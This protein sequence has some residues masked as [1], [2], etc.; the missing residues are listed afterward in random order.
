MEP[1]TQ[2]TSGKI[3]VSLIIG[4][5]L[6]FAAGAFWESRRSA[7]EL[8]Q[9]ESMVK[10]SGDTAATAAGTST[11][12]VST[13]KRTT[14]AENL[15]AVVSAPLSSQAGTSTASLLVENQSAGA[16]VEVTFVSVAWPV[17][18]AVRELKNGVQGNILG[19]AR[20]GA[21]TNGTVVRLLRSTV[22]GGHYAVVLY[23]DIG[24]QTFNYKEDVL[25]EG[26]RSEFI[27]E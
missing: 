19:A 18:V 3:I 12:V 26:V 6:G 5:I 20:V 11:I 9:S 7:V 22:A 23:R 24:D 15:S 27:A 25:I 4:L 13:E 17:W 2:N 14:S 8:P 16:S 21:G 10:T 1:A